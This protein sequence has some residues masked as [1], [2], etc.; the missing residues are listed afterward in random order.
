VY[1][2]IHGLKNGAYCIPQAGLAEINAPLQI[3]HIYPW[4]SQQHPI[5]LPTTQFR[6]ISTQMRK[7]HYDLGIC[8]II[9]CLFQS[10]IFLLKI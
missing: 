1:L 10:M 8:N 4:D 9:Q 6:Y 2:L 3:R 7:K 5:D